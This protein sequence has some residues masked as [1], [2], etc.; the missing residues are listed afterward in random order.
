MTAG[1]PCLLVRVVK[2]YTPTTFHVGRRELKRQRIDVL[3]D[4]TTE[5]GLREIMPTLNEGCAMLGP[6]RLQTYI[7]ANDARQMCRFFE[8][9]YGETAQAWKSKNI[10][11]P[12][13]EDIV[14]DCS[15][16]VVN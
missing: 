13:L 3:M 12:P 16:E 15:H 1:I 11:A 14:F 2:T 5:D 8:Y 10:D 6:K 4:F 9:K 7:Y